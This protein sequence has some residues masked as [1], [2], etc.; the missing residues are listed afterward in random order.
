M[1]DVSIITD[2]G[3]AVYPT[4]QTN[5]NE[6]FPVIHT[7]MR[8]TEVIINNIH[9]ETV[10]NSVVTFTWHIYEV[11]QTLD[12]Y[13]YAY[14]RATYLVTMVTDMVDWNFG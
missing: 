10:P 3:S 12:Y 4:C 13:L 14:P 8:S 11:S 7:S 1:D 9:T 6:V 5:N 2:T